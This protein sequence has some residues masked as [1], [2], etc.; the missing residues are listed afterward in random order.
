MYYKLV[1]LKIKNFF[2]QFKYI[3]IFSSK[4]IAIAVGIRYCEKYKFWYSWWIRFLYYFLSSKRVENLKSKKPN[5]F[6]K[7]FKSKNKIN[8]NK[9]S[10]QAFKDYF[11]NL[12]NAISHTNNA[13]AEEFCSNNN[14]NEENCTFP[15]LDQ[16]ITVGE[17]KN[18]VKRL[19]RKKRLVVTLF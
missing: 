5:E 13:E 6:W 10:I 19:K 7:Y 15:E 17:V 12:S 4:T 11:D 18:A 1:D 2:I 8:G 16:P 9:I 3:K 14:F